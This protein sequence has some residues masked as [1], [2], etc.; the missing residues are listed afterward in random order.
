MDLNYSS[1]YK[2]AK[3]N[4]VYFDHSHLKIATMKGADSLDFLNRI[5][6]NE[7]LNLKD[8]ESIQTILTSDKGRIID[9]VTLLQKDNKEILVLSSNDSLDSTI[10]WMK[11]YIIMDDVSIKENTQYKAI[12]L[13]GPRSITFVR[14][15]FSLEDFD[16]SIQKFTIHQDSGTVI[17]RIPA[18]CEISMLL[19]IPKDNENVLSLIISTLKQL[20]E[21]DREL[22]RI[23][24]G[25]GKS[26]NELNEK[27]NPL[28]AGLLHIIN[29]KK[30]CYIGQEVIARLDSYNKVKQRLFGIQSSDELQVGDKIVIENSEVGI[31]T[32][33]LKLP[34]ETTIGLCY[35]RGEYA[36]DNTTT[37]VRADEGNVK[38]A[39]LKKLPFSNE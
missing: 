14:E 37:E 19:L 22:L 6:T 31:I 17:A 7:V 35:V 10:R 4:V 30:G 23:E 16:S 2:E 8:N 39:M 5:S 28:E 27:Y 15:F 32:S 13:H 25:M 20:S 21:F 24:A 38:S 11:K 12:E 1:A 26:P 29:F 18:I 36:H 9:V 3:N 33:T 34:T